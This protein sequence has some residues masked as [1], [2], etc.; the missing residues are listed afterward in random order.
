[1]SSPQDLLRTALTHH[2]AGRMEEAKTAYGVLATAAQTDSDAARLLAMVATQSGQHQAARDTLE[3][4]L[5]R[6]P[7][8]P[9]VHQLLALIDIE[10]GALNDAL[11][12][13]LL[14]LQ[15]SP[16]SPPL[17]E[18]LGRIRLAQG[19]LEDAEKAFLDALEYNPECAAAFNGLGRIAMALQHW[20][21]SEE[22]FKTALELKPGWAAAWCNLGMLFMRQSRWS[23]AR[24][25]L[26]KATQLSP[27]LTAAWCGLSDTLMGLHLHDEALHAAQSAVETNPRSYHAQDTLGRAL[28]K[29]DR[30]EEAIDCFN[31]ARGLH[32]A[33]IEALNNLSTVYRDLGQL[34]TAMAFIEQALSIDEHRAECWNNR[35]LIH[36]E[37]TDA[38]AALSCFAH[39]TSLLPSHVPAQL[40]HVHLLW[41]SGL[42][43]PAIEQLE[44]G[45]A[46]TPTST[47][48]HSR[49]IMAMHYSPRFAPSRLR[50]EAVN[51]AMSMEADDSAPVPTENSATMRRIGLISADFR[52]HPVGRAIHGVLK[53]WTA[54]GVEVIAYSNHTQEDSVTASIRQ[55]CHMWR[56]IPH[57]S[58]TQV[59][60]LVQ[61]DSI[62]VLI[63]LS[64]HTSGHR[65][66][67][68]VKRPAPVQLTWMGFF[69]TTGLTCFDGVL[70]DEIVFPSTD[71]PHSTE[72]V[73]HLNRCFSGMN[74]GELPDVPVTPPP[75]IMHGHLT[76]GSF[77]NPL[78]YNLDVVR[79]WVNILD[80]LPNARLLLRYNTLN[81]DVTRQYVM[82]MFENAGLDPTR[83]DLDSGI[84]RKALFA[85]YGRVDIALDPHPVNGGMTTVEALWMGVPVLGLR[86]T[87][88]SSR[89]GDSLVTAAGH[90]EWVVD[91]TAELT[92]L[93]VELGS[94]VEQ[95]IDIRRT[96][97]TSLQASE[98]CDLDG[99]GVHS[100]NVI[101]R[102]WNAQGR[103]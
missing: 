72:P 101:Q 53:A 33:P 7:D 87:R 58:D 13:I 50:K 76:F 26:V 59:S 18:T 4:F 6:T 10:A 2:K 41:A 75:S 74:T 46:A 82:E 96:L 63:D 1:M 98:L 100:L 29:A 80:A 5:S 88:Q 34:D 56:T 20:S 90:P 55:H 66:G 86:G 37:R 61:S 31:T 24:T 92:A 22:R 40:N 93:A 97:R 62:D 47:D 14:A 67:V 79:S 51:W 23:D 89:I 54:Q 8:S 99:L 91:T 81:P 11:Q 3:Q 43:E 12:H 65:L 103:G 69:G 21:G 19:R 60:D 38:D 39:A 73:Q 16:T 27:T 17:L 52:A 71:Q 44:I 48:L 77:N 32:T 102:V 49:L 45:L 15:S 30:L 95:R 9:D 64:G 94:D 25:V 68:F 36:L 84:E 42:L 70:S 28:T 35:G 83:L 57:M 78:K 85:E